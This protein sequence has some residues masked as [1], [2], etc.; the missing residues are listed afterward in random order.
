[1]ASIELSFID[2][3]KVTID[4]KKELLV[5]I[6]DEYGEL[7]TQKKIK[8]GVVE[9][10]VPVLR[11]WIIEVFNGDKKVFNHQLKLKGQVV[12]IKF[13]DVA[14]GDAITWPAYIEE[15]R[16]K[17]KCKVYVKTRYP[18]LFEKSSGVESS[19]LST[20]YVGISSSL[21]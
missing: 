19:M 17:Y 13:I 21:V 14:L 4:S 11:E 15:F 2:Y 8:K 10:N 18:E 5:K 12:F 6:K 7:T 1:M 3:P 16:K 20:S 9:F